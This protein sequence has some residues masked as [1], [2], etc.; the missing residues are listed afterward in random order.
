[1]DV[2]KHNTW[3][4]I[5]DEVCQEQGALGFK[6]YHIVIMSKY[7]VWGRAGEQEGTHRGG[8]LPQRREQRVICLRLEGPRDR[9]PTAPVMMVIDAGTIQTP[10]T[11]QQI[12]R[13][14]CKV[15]KEQNGK[16]EWW[17]PPPQLLCSV[18]PSASL[19]FPRCHQSLREESYYKPFTLTHTGYSNSAACAHMEVCMTDGKH[20][21]VHKGE[22][23]WLS[24]I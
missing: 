11:L 14:F 23:V 24:L 18:T 19:W 21:S 4:L 20:R 10:Q 17:A 7:G 6:Q 5:V 13:L 9:V 2:F 12:K 16:G 8:N 22:T 15:V 1:M 3:L